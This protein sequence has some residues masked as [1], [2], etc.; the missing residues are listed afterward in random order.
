M[1]TKTARKRWDEV[2]ALQQ[3]DDPANIILMGPHT[4]YQYRTDAKHLSFVLARYK[5]CAKMLAGRTTVLEVGCGDAF[6]T[7]IVAQTV[8]NVVGID[9]D[10]Q[11]IA[12]T[13]G[14]L[15]FLGNCVFRQCD[16]TQAK[17]LDEQFD[18]IYS[19]DVLE[20][21]DPK[22]ERR[23]MQNCCRAL[24]DKGMFVIGTPNEKA[25]VYASASSRAGHIN[26]KDASALRELL[27]RYFETT[28]LFGMNDEVVHTGF[29]DMAHYLFGV[30]VGVKGR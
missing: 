22:L 30:C 15:S 7:P 9:W 13:E 27:T 5:F 1:S 23:F 24:E 14:R 18:G 6:G 20:H 28:I 12:S 4:A 19:V 2:A 21:I 16:M 26:L 10:A 29:L 11:L 25:A 17:G 8:K 3:Y